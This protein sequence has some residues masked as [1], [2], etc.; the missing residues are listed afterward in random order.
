MA[1]QN[2]QS[3]WTTFAH[4]DIIYDLS[5]LRTYTTKFARPAQSNK[6]PEFYGVNISFSHHCFTQRLP[7]KGGIYD[8]TLRF[9]VDGEQ[10]I[11]DVRRWRLSR[12]LPTIVESLPTRKCM[13]TG[14][15]NYFTVSVIDEDGASVDYE[16]F[17]RA[18]KPG[19]GRISLH[20]ESAYVREE[21]YGTSRPKGLRIGFF[22]I[23]HN[24]LNE[25]PIHA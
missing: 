3:P 5:H 6:T 16:V 21:S 23:L 12:N 1:S 24:T 10:R 2:K 15:S 18:W 14:R 22:V 7:A 4:G 17:F 20:V 11:F 9:D 13:Q 25:L 19:K 8:P